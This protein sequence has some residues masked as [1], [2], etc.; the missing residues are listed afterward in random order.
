[1]S[2]GNVHDQHGLMPL[3]QALQMKHVPER[4][5][6]YRPRKVRAVKAYDSPELRRWLR[7]QQIL[8]RIAARASSRARPWAAPVG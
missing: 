6:H 3:V 7:R 4:G 5:R 2:A 1:M 8:P